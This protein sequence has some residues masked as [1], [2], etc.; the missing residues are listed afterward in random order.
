MFR[1]SKVHWTTMKKYTHNTAQPMR[2]RVQIC[3]WTAL[4]TITVLLQ[5]D[6][7]C[8]RNYFT[9]IKSNSGPSDYDGLRR[10]AFSGLSRPQWYC[11]ISNLSLPRCF[12]VA[13][14]LMS[15][16]LEVRQ[17]RY[18]CRQ[19]CT[20]MFQ[21]IH[22]P[23]SW[24]W[25]VCRTSSEKYHDATILPEAFITTQHFPLGHR[26]HRHPRPGDLHQPGLCSLRPLQ[27]RL[28]DT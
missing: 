14:N 19:W 25:Y 12:L 20:D 27:G 26:D 28:Q 3:P 21:S 24:S 5:C 2:G 23:Q 7:Y 13:L 17:W 16:V 9:V 8:Y 1:F 11:Y 10:L 18:W 15:H 6:D 4:V 22:V